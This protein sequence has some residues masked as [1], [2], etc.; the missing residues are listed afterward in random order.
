MDSHQK[1]AVGLPLFIILR[2]QAPP[3]PQTISLGA[4][5][6][7][8]K[9]S[10]RV[11]DNICGKGLTPQ[12]L[13]ALPIGGEEDVTVNLSPSEFSANRTFI[14]GRAEVRFCNSKATVGH[15]V[16]CDSH[17]TW[18]KKK[19]NW[20]HVKCICVIVSNSKRHGEGS[21]DGV[22]PEK[23]KRGLYSKPKRKY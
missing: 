14:S 17:K 7:D 16:V 21:E 11:D 23:N 15:V 3:Q 5:H 19:K 12:A 8:L 13:T 2:P 4:L 10:E 20:L 9:R 6:I 1:E 22:A 18:I